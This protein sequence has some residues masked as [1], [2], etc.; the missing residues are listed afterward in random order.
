MAINNHLRPAALITGS[1]KRIGAQITKALAMHGYNLIIHYYNSAK[2]AEELANFVTQKYHVEAYIIGKNLVEEGAPAQLIGFALE[3][4]PKLN[5]LINNA[6]IFIPDNVFT[7]EE[8]VFTNHYNIHVRAPFFLA[9]ALFKGAAAHNSSIIAGETFVNKTYINN[10]NNNNININNI[11]IINIIDK[12]IEKKTAN[13]Y[14]SYLLSKKGL[15]N[16]NEMLAEYTSINNIS[17]KIE[18]IYPGKISEVNGLENSLEL[19]AIIKKIE[20]ILNIHC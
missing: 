1:A 17:A 19:K 9:Q 20:K 10:N 13:N 16:L 14:F 4:F 15:E 18:A 12:F 2:E 11:S 3:K 8:R 5:V 6:S 7:A